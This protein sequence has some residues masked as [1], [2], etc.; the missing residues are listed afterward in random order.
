MDIVQER[1]EREYQM[2]LITT[3][4]TVIYEVVASDGSI[5]R[6]ENPARMPDPARIVEIREPI[7]KV[8]V[9]VPQDYVGPVITLCNGKRGVQR[10]LAYHGRHVHLTYELPMS[11]IVHRLLRSA[12]VD[13]AR[14]CLDGLRVPRVPGIGCRQDGSADQRR[15]G[16]RAVGDRPP[17]ELAR[18]RTRHRCADARVDPATDVRRRD[19]GRHRQPYHRARDI[20]ALRKNVLAKCYG[21]DITRKRKL[22]EKQKAG[23]KRMKQVGS[24]EIPQEAFLAVLQAE[25][26]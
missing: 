8:V 21:G 18:A 11:E 14:L 22:L 15:Q 16:R 17:L 12:E 6:V 2:E 1:L 5:E 23:K 20:K 7:V 25:E 13:L 10:D 3:A 26:R 19:P 4:P 9:F 24:V